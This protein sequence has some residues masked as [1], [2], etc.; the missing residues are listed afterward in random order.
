MP[1]GE[2]L[3][4][5]LDTSAYPLLRPKSPTVR[6]APNSHE[7]TALINQAFSL[8]NQPSRPR[9]MRARTHRIAAAVCYMPIQSTRFPSSTDQA[10]SLSLQSRVAYPLS[11]HQDSQAWRAV[12]ARNRPCFM[13]TGMILHPSVWAGVHGLLVLSNFPGRA[14]TV[15][16]NRRRKPSC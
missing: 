6:L 8:A 4:F 16:P 9:A 11:L 15:C 2:V 12:Q 7:E 1:P 5:T 14:R 10:D 13:G 3:E